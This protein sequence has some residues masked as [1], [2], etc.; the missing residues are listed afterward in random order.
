MFEVFIGS[1]LLGAVGALLIVWL[2]WVG[3]LPRFSSSVEIGILE[4]E[5]KD[6]SA[7]M[8]IKIRGGKEITDPEVRHSDN[9]RDDVWRQRT[10]SFFVSSLL[11]V[12][13]GG[14]TAVLFVG[15]EVKNIIDPLVIGKLLSAGALWSSFYSFIDVKKTDEAIETIRETMDAETLKKVEE[16][17][18]KAL[19]KVEE[20]KKTFEE[21]LEKKINQGNSVITELIEKYNDLVDEYEKLKTRVP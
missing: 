7:S 12:I 17:E 16:Q 1:F 4:D 14:A 21:E 10:R 2:R 5:Y 3:T 8:T 6:L 11:Y 9:L 18:E 13:L 19:K 15:L 20:L